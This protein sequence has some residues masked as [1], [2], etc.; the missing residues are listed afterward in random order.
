MNGEDD[1]VTRE[2]TRKI[3]EHNDDAILIANYAVCS[4][5]INMK[6]LHNLI[7]ASPLKAFTTVAQS[8]GRL[9]RKHNSKTEANI[10]D[11]VDVFT[12]RHKPSGIFWKE[13]QHRV[14]KSYNPEGYPIR[15]AEISLKS[16]EEW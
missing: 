15:S 2:K 6:K 13:F 11:L 4:T 8:L 12:N 3:L 10:Y 16:F 5:G 14:K 9:M 7:F 1:A